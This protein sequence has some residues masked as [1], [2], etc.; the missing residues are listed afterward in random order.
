MNFASISSRLNNAISV[1]ARHIN[2]PQTPR[3]NVNNTT[4]THLHLIDQKLYQIL[5]DLDLAYVIVVHFYIN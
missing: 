5:F 4:L 1:L 3:I 2:I